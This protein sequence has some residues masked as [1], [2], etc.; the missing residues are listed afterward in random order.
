[1]AEP[2]DQG[3]SATSVS[4]PGDM[5]TRRG[6]RTQRVPRVLPGPT[7]PVPCRRGFLFP[8]WQSRIVLVIV[9]YGQHRTPRHGRYGRE[10]WP[11]RLS[12]LEV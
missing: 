5:W 1:M 6:R 8:S 4:Q 2:W 7:P 9:A 3:E 10:L 11:T 12:V